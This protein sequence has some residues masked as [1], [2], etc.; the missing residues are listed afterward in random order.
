MHRLFRI[1][2]VSLAVIVLILS[3]TDDPVSAVGGL[4]PGAF[5]AELLFGSPRHGDKVSHFLCYGAL[6]GAAGIGFSDGGRRWTPIAAGLL[7]Y[8]ATI[9][10]IQAM[11]G[12]RQA[13]GLDLLANAGGI[14]AGLIGTALFQRFFGPGPQ[15]A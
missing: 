2:A 4:D 10:G 9:E 15:P 5:L 6:A 13:D 11:G 3:V 14:A 7:L 1:A 8:G 12:V